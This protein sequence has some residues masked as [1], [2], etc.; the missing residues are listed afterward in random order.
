MEYAEFERAMKKG[1]MFADEVS[2][3]NVSLR[4]LYAEIGKTSTEADIDKYRTAF[5]TGFHEGRLAEREQQ[6][7]AMFARIRARQGSR[8]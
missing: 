2:N 6:I 4:M 3:L 5:W 7:G 8:I 1:Y